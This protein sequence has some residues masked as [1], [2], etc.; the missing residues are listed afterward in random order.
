MITLTTDQ[1]KTEVPPQH[2]RMIDGKAY[3]EVFDA[4]TG[5]YVWQEIQL[6]DGRKSYGHP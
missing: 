5:R 2:R 3:I 1:Y 6:L 4:E